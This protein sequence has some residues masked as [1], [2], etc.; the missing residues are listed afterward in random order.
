MTGYNTAYQRNT[1]FNCVDYTLSR[2]ADPILGISLY[3]SPVGAFIGT[4]V[5]TDAQPAEFLHASALLM[6]GTDVRTIIHQNGEEIHSQG[7]AD[8]SMIPAEFSV[9]KVVSPFL[10]TGY[11]NFLGNP[12]REGKCKNRV[13]IETRVIEP[14]QLIEFLRSLSPQLFQSDQDTEAID[15]FL[16]VLQGDLD[17]VTPEGTIHAFE[18]GGTAIPT[19]IQI[20]INGGKVV[21]DTLYPD[22]DGIITFPT[23][24]DIRLRRNEKK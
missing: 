10:R 13:G 4:S 22:K 3:D 14:Q 11:M 21:R 7:I 17:R 9:I 12:A 15:W 23:K 6:N 5:E 19:A 2:D 8:T 16:K 20:S 24:G 18:G 1:D